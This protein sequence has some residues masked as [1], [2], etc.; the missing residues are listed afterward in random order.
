MS[1]DGSRNL[2]STP[3][4]KHCQD[5]VGQEWDHVWGERRGEE[6]AGEEDDTPVS[7]C[8]TDARLGIIP[9]LGRGAVSVC[10]CP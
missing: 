6:G 7:A 2:T 10:L 4:T 3:A 9:Y 5:G 1:V 8:D